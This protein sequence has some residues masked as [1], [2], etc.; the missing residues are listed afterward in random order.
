MGESA[1]LMAAGLGTRM[2]P[3][4]EKTPKPLLRVQERPMIETVIEGL[5]RRPVEKIYV[6]TGHLAE[7]FAYL[8]RKYPQVTLISNP[9][10]RTKN[11]LSSIYAAR[12][13]LGQGD[14]FIC[15][16]DLFIA[17]A[18]VFQ[19]KLTHSCY[20][21]CLREGYTDDWV[22]DL[23]DGRIVRVGKGGTDTCHMV[24]VSYFREPDACILKKEIEKAYQAKDHDGMFWDEV[25]DRNLDKLVLRVEPVQEGQIVEID[26]VKELE[27]M[28]E[29]V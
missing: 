28:N 22:F 3:L 14:C 24:G 21:G 15:E 5:L 1:I 17:D 18:S 29:S 9:D 20:Y 8:T 7:Q 2:M 27:K 25:V 6:V 26:T 13:V 4:T 11:N 12:E 16:S 10:Y 23:K 19:K